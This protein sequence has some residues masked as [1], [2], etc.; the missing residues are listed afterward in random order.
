MQSGDTLLIGDGKYDMR[1]EGAYV[2]HYY[3]SN[4]DHGIKPIALPIINK[5]NIS[6]IGEGAE[7]VFHG[8]ILP[9]VVDGSKNIKLS[10]FSI[11]YEVPMYAQCD[12]IETSEDRTVIKFDGKQF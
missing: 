6:I 10:G 1:V 12:V 5:E 9:V 8:E 2:R 11:D 3:I 7:L 4:N